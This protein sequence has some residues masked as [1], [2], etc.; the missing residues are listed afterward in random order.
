MKGFIRTAGLA[1]KAI[2]L[3]L[4]VVMFLIVGMNVFSRYV[5]N[6][7]LGWADELSRFIFIWISFLG[8]VLAYVDNEHIGLDFIVEKMPS[9]KIKLIFRLIGDLGIL[10]VV[11][12][13]TYYGWYVATSATNVSPALY[14][15]MKTIYMIVPIS[16]ALM[17]LINISKI[18]EHVQELISELK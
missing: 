3:I 15:P 4:I 10:I 18:S 17:V 7:S 8:A 13:L 12:F 5:L 9:Q 1:Y 11:S 2:I 14:I 6:S 16:A